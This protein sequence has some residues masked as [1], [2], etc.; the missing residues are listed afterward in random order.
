MNVD[1]LVAPRSGSLLLLDRLCRLRLLR[2]P[3]HLSHALLQYLQLSRPPRILL[4][5]LY[6]RYPHRVSMS[7]LRSLGGL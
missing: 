5:P 1:V 4:H 3:A 2:L 6:L 7:L